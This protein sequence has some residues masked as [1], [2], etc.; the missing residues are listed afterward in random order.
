MYLSSRWSDAK[1]SCII[2]EEGLLKYTHCSQ[3]E[4]ATIHASKTG[5]FVQ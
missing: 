4:V 2:K 3:D 1:L 5:I